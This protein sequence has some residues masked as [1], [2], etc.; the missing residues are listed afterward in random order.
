[1]RLQTKI[2]EGVVTLQPS[3]WQD[4]W[5]NHS[6]DVSLWWIPCVFFN[7]TAFLYC[8]TCFLIRPEYSCRSIFLFRR[9]G[10]TFPRSRLPIWNWPQGQ[11]R[12]EVEF[13]IYNIEFV[14]LS[15]AFI[16][17]LQAVAIEAAVA[18]SFS[19]CIACL[20]RFGC[21]LGLWL[22]WSGDDPDELEEWYLP[23]DTRGLPVHFSYKSILGLWGK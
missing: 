20:I 12:A 23:Q 16:K 2:D 8:F 5:N 17:P 11:T 9:D 14:L 4:V 1:M 21:Q 10:T 7:H 19:L 13:H 22:C 3:K 6:Y 18:F 15:H